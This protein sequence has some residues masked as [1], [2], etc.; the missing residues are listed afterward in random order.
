MVTA[1]LA[2]DVDGDGWIDLLLATEWGPV[3]YWRNREGSGWEDRSEAAGFA[4]AGTGWWSALATGDFNGDGRPDFVAGNLGLNTAYRASPQEPALIY[5]GNM[6]GRR[7]GS[8]S[9]IEA[10]YENGRLLPRR[11][12]KDL[13]AVIRTLGR[14]YRRTV[15]YAA[16]TLPEILGEDVLAEA[17]RFAATEFRSGVFLSQ[18]DGRYRFAPLPRIAQIAPITALAVVDLNGDGALDLVAGQNDHSP[19]ELVGR[20]D[21]GIGQVLRGDG[22][23]GFTAVDPA[24]SGFVVPGEVKSITWLAGEGEVG[25]VVLAL[26]RDVKEVSLPVLEYSQVLTEADLVELV[27]TS[28]EIARCV[29]ISKR[30]SVPESVSFSRYSKMPVR[31]C[32]EGICFFCFFCQ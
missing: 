13:T 23:G 8:A 1:A 25:D 20:F 9:I 14:K 15:D 6:A 19:I 10:Y 22:V 17:E 3:R 30:R 24:V 7:R 2:Q 27:D 11:E 28:R 16:A 12:L 18:P 29:A 21:G 32:P 4:A 26:A 31:D 5:Y